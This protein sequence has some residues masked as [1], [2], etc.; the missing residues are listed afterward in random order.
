[1]IIDL[2]N[3]GTSALTHRLV[4]VRGDGG[5]SALSR[6][7][8]LVVVTEDDVAD[9]AI[10]IAVDASREHPSRVIAVVR[11]NRRGTSRLDAQIRIGGDAGASEV[12]VLRMYGPLAEHGDSVI[13]PLLLPDAPV[14]VWWSGAGP[15]VPS[16]DPI[17]R[18]GQ[19][20]ITDAARAKNPVKWLQQLAV[21]HAPGDTDL[22]WSRITRWRSVLAAALDTRP[23]ERVTKISVTGGSDSPSLELLADWLGTALDAPVT[24]HRGDAGSGVTAVTLT[25]ASGP[26]TLER[27]GG[28]VGTLT[29]PGRP[30][31]R[32]AM[33]RRTDTDCLVEELRRLD[34]DEL[35][36]EVL[37]AG[38]P[39][40]RTAAKKS[41][42]RKTSGKVQA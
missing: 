30:E 7:L 1:M 6:V 3:T 31:R 11:G 9:A 2:P 21:G 34:P 16:E 18:M 15:D 4:S 35:F 23:Y 32:I 28:T 25:R 17:G 29:Q 41:P 27:P 24:K 10:E 8:T 42:A 39:Q 22:A 36:G 33:Q 19:R 13:V 12:I 26:I 5:A 38:V 37:R 20:R 14:V 40:K